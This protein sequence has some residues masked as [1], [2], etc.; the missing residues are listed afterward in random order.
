L[1]VY[2][3]RPIDQAGES[4]W[5]GSL[6]IHIEQKLALAGYGAFRPAEAYVANPGD[7]DH[8]AFID[9]TN[10]Q[11][12]YRASAFVAILPQGMPTLGTPVE[13]SA[14]L[15]LNKP[16]VIFT[17][18]TRSVQLAAWREAGAQIV[19]LSDDGVRIPESADLKAMLERLPNPEDT[20]SEPGHG[21]LFVKYDKGALPLTR[22]HDTDAGFDL[23]TLEDAELH[24][25]ERVLIKTG[26]RGA[27]PV[28]W[29]GRITGRSSALSRW[30]IKVHEG[31]I[32][33]GY[34]GELMIGVTYTGLGHVDVPRG[35][36]LA[37]YILA[38]VWEG[39][40]EIVEE[41]PTTL[42]GEKGWGSSGE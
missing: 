21:T 28:G 36:R 1:F 12:I 14:A 24:S 31:I 20:G 18:I 22:A 23:A 40:I 35:T 33:A 25:G 26:V 8:A 41:L 9:E 5:L 10:N 34:T 13:I 4:S 6:A 16:T 19:D 39:D 17:D 15:M 27:V 42:R 29:Y 37:Q 3:A 38:P 30:Q 32:D 11:A 2:L 7:L